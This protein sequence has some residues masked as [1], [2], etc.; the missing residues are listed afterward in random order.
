M[1]PQWLVARSLE[2]G[3]LISLLDDYEADPHNDEVNIWLLHPENR[4]RMRK[5]QALIEFLK[6][7][8]S[9]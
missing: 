5:V 3:E 7:A 4:K 6:A 2:E 9:G 1:L 8:Y